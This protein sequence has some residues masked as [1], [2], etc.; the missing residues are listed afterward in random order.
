MWNR[1]FGLICLSV[2]GFA[3]PVLP[4]N[5]S[6]TRVQ[7]LSLVCDG[8][9]RTVVFTATDLNN[10]MNPTANRF[11]QGVEV[12]LT[13]LKVLQRLRIQL[14]GNPNKTFL[15]MGAGEVSAR[16]Q[17]TGFFQVTTDT[18]GNIAFEIIATCKGKK[19]LEGILVLSFFS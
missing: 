2:V 11:V 5:A 6:E 13:R 9:E 15:T 1:L 4:A 19:P 8:T 10:T 7:N 16:N 12:S 14:A 17:F 3:F 18:S